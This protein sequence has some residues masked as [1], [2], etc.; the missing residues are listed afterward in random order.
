EESD[1][2]SYGLVNGRAQWSQ[3]FGSAVD[4]GV[5]GTNLTDKEYVLGTL[6]AG[7]TLGYTGT[8]YGPS[9]MWGVDVRYS[10]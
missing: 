1:I 7:S 10:F 9:R 4:V 6:G 3:V 5:F 2:R 8:N